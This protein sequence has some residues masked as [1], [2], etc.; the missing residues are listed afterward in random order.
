MAR[1]ASTDHP[2][3]AGGR[4]R[5]RGTGGRRGGAAED[6]RGRRRAAEAGLPM[7]ANRHRCRLTIAMLVAEVDRGGPE[8]RHAIT[9]A[10]GRLESR[11]CIPILSTL[12]QDDSPPVQVT[13]ALALATLETL[14]HNASWQTRQLIAGALGQT[15]APAA[16]ESLLD[17]LDDSDYDVR[18]G[19]AKSLGLLG[20]GDAIPALRQAAERDSHPG[21][22]AYAAEALA[23]LDEPG[24]RA[25][26]LR[27]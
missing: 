19:A 2:R 20:E 7:S 9:V 11:E 16:V 18:M 6:H 10:L 1:G 24:D 22:Q 26:P 27:L 12:S 14:R 17:M 3:P 8:D 15:G 23:K 21:A 13:A 25:V 4:S 5:A